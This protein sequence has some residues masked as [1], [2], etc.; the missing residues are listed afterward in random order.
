MQMDFFGQLKLLKWSFIF[1]LAFNV[2]FMIS[3]TGF[4]VF[5]HKSNKDA[6]YENHRILTENN[7]I[8]NSLKALNTKTD[9]NVFWENLQQLEKSKTKPKDFNWSDKILNDGLN[10]LGTTDI[11]SIKLGLNEWLASN[12]ERATKTYQSLDRLKGL[13][14]FSLIF[15]FIF[16]I[17][18]P[19][20]ILGLIT[21]RIYVA[22]AQFTD[23]A[24]TAI[25]DWRNQFNPKD[26]EQFKN[27]EFWLKALLLSVKS[28]TQ[29]SKH[30]VLYFLNDLSSAL[31]TELNSSPAEE[32]TVNE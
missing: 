18:L 12:Y 9:L 16:G 31:L 14:V 13:L 2:F 6:G 20:F 15:S 24:T 11:T 21:K 3:G 25:S 28:A 19:L 8:L 5:Y 17:L 7:L 26:K 10:N 22:Q 4:I 27:P 30:P 32:R 29:F 1:I 23:W